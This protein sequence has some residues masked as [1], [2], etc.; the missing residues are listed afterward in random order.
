[1]RDWRIYQFNLCGCANVHE[2]TRTQHSS[3]T[4]WTKSTTTTL[5]RS[6]TILLGLFRYARSRNWIVACPVVSN[7]LKMKTDRERF[8]DKWIPEPYSGCWLWTGF[9]QS[10]GY[11]QIQINRKPVP[12]HRVAWEMFRGDIPQGMRICHKCDTRSCVN[13]EHLFT[14]TQKDNMQDCIKKGRIFRPIGQKN[15]NCKI[16]E[17]DA[18]F[19]R[20]SLASSD[21][22]ALRF[23]IKR[24][25]VNR[26]KSKEQWRFFPTND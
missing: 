3:F 22:L 13:P 7:R 18:R 8:D 15:F 21:S 9:V 2:M 14:G 10:S 17:S 19:I 1:M 11:G 4:Y 20:E 24:R 23:G 25:Q 12:A 6:V 16:T 5:K 26:I